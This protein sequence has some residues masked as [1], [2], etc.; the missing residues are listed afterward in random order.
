LKT[1][2]IGNIVLSRRDSLSARKVYS[3]QHNENSGLGD[4]SQNLIG[5]LEVVISS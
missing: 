4:T 2:S 5:R 1:W 3:Y